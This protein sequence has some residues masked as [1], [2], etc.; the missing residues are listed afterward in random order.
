MKM[1]I[2]NSAVHL[3]GY[4]NV[5][6]RDSRILLSPSRGKF[7]EQ[8]RAK[9]FQKALE[10][11]ENV[12]LL[13]NHNEQRHLGN[14]KDGT[15]KLW[16][17][18]IGLRAEAIISDAEVVSKAET[19]E[20]R[21]W[22]F[23]FKSLKEHWDQAGEGLQRRFLEEIMIPEV[24]IL[25]TTPAYIATSVEV[26]SEEQLLEYRGFEFSQEPLQTVDYS[27]SHQIT[28]QEIEYLRLRQGAY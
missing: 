2:R 12:K 16:E 3:S 13:F 15:L 18:N 7:V 23:G 28:A 21:G 20:L 22:S 17:D 14:T 1:E 27:I 25:D 5:V 11:M 6:E 26:R 9:T 8:V 24:S 10:A 4:V 19:N